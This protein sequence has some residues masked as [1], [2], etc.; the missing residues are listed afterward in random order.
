MELS[1]Q[2]V[3]LD[4]AKRLKELGVKQHS[5]F[6]FVKRN[7]KNRYSIAYLSK[8]FIDYNNEFDDICSAYTTT[9]LGELLP[10]M[11]NSTPLEI[12][13]GL[14]FGD[15]QPL[16][17][18]RYYNADL[19]GEPDKSMA[20]AMAKMLIHLIENKLMDISNDGK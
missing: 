11:I 10:A 8:S 3:S 17:C 19:I 4:L 9:E 1:E 2:V 18:V 20:N 14:K 13:K 15:I 5:L 16:Y 6:Y 7:N 12:L